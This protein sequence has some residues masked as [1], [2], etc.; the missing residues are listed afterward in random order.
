MR[1]S[2]RASLVGALTMTL[3]G[4]GTVA[5]YGSSDKP[6]A[7]LKVHASAASSAASVTWSKPSSTGGSPITKYVVTAEPSKRTCTTTGLHCKVTGLK[8]GVSYGFT[9]VAYNKH[10]AGT[11]SRLSNRATP[12]KSVARVLVVT[13]SKGLTNGESVK[14]SGTGFT[15]HDTVY[16]IECQ[17]DAT[18][19]NGCQ[20]I[21]TLPTAVTIS[22][23]GVLAT[24]TFKVATGTIGNGT[25]GTTTA[26]ASSCAVS[27]G[28]ASGGDSAQAVITFKVP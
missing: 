6:S 16:L 1:L 28:N 7:P 3:V 5:A 25:C 13:P 26:N 18:G 27:A 8:D 14:V 17:A 22:S 10:G 20:A 19:Q 15:P 12:A 11:P 2:L 21:T 24:T 9:V 23:S 4:L